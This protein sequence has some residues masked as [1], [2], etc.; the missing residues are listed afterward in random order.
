MLSSDYLLL[1]NRN[2]SIKQNPYKSHSFTAALGFPPPSFQLS[3]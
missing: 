1:S 2:I 3:C